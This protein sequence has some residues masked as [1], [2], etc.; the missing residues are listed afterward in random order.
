MFRNM[1]INSKVIFC[2]IVQLVV[3]ITI[4]TVVSLDQMNDMAKTIAIELFEKKLV[5]DLNSTQRYIND[6]YGKLSLQDTTLVDINGKSIEN[7]FTMVDSISSEKE[8]YATIFKKQGVVWKRVSTSIR[9]DRG[10]RIV[11]T[12]LEYDSVK[13]NLQNGETFIGVAPIDNELYLTG[14]LPMLSDTNDVIGAV[15]VGVPMQ[16]INKKIDFETHKTI[17]ILLILS[18]LL[19][20]FFTFIMYKVITHL[21]S[22]IKKTIN[23]LKNLTE[24]EN[25]INKRLQVNSKDEM[26]ELAFYFNK[27]LDEFYH[28]VVLIMKNA[29]NIHDKSVALS[30][31]AHQLIKNAMI[32]NDHAL[33]ISASTDEIN[34]NT[35]IIIDLAE[36]S[37]DSVTN[38]ANSSENLTTLINN[39]AAV[40][41]ETNANVNSTL[42]Y[43]NNLEATIEETG[44]DILT[45]VKDI[46]SITTAIEKVNNT[47]SLVVNNSQIAHDK[48]KII[49]CSASTMVR[50]VNDL[51]DLTNRFGKTSK[52][53]NN[54]SDQ[55]NILVFNMSL[56]AARMGDSGRCFLAVISEMKALTKESADIM[57]NISNII[58]QIQRAASNTNNILQ[59]MV[60]NLY[61][62]NIAIISSINEQKFTVD[63]I[64]QSQGALSLDASNVNVKITNLIECAKNIISYTNQAVVVFSDIS[65]NSFNSAKAS[66][67]IT[68]CSTIARNGV[69]EIMKI[70]Q[71]IKSRISEMSKNMSSM[72][73]EIHTT[74]MHAETT[75]K[76]S[77]DLNQ[78]ADELK[79]QAEIFSL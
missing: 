70:T 18:L 20:V 52:L 13:A 27:I 58:E 46:H 55:T 43:I 64:V 73:Y 4:L 1:N 29:N 65:K 45:L 72:Q 63:E 69:Q 44:N 17:V 74:T 28:I 15:F 49:D 68:N 25:N 76:A 77:N 39:L 75:K 24:D 56:E 26:S 67:E 14:Y 5:G 62:M 10:E 9:N 8:I 22:P 51:M 48:S 23:L 7:D 66:N 6:F 31:T 38:V 3:V 61:E 33:L 50:E 32:M 16:E 79:K 57:D 42:D 78:I 40:T 11:Y 59:S 54:I 12:R 37:N 34:S 35:N 2:T 36:S 30:A 71:E 21:H 41:E 53:I 19:I 60:S 47:F